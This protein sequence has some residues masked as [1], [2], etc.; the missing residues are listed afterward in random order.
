[1]AYQTG[2][3][4]SQEDL[5]DK[6]QTFAAANGWT[7][8]NFDTSND[9]LSLHKGSIYVHFHWDNAS[10]IGIFQSLGFISTGTGVGSHTDDSGNLC[11]ETGAISSSVGHKVWLLEQ[12]YTAYHFFEN[13]AGAEDYIHIVVEQDA[14]VFR[15]FS[16]G[17]IT[18]FNDFTGGEYAVGHYPYATI[19]QQTAYSN[20]RMCLWDAHCSTS[21]IMGYVH[22]ESMPNQASGGKWGCIGD[23]TAARGN[24]GNSIARAIVL[25]GVRGGPY[26]QY[27]HRQISGAQAFIPFAPIPLWYIDTSTTPDHAYL[28]GYVPNVRICNITNLVEGVEIT[29]GGDTW[30][31]FPMIRK[32]IP[33]DNTAGYQSGSYGIA[34]KKVT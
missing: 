21:T 9:K 19:S 16:F 6:L 34:Y 29:Y 26:S 28:L 25:G 15:H 13:G 23:P 31:P 32:L 1:M 27:S 22:L 3:A 7:V 17:E 10:W 20:N 14:G 33:Y 2:T 5:M 30:I 18:K 12:S 11:A 8:D 24:D 4:S